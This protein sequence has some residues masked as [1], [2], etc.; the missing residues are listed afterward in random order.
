MVRLRP[1]RYAPGTAR[2]TDLFRVLSPIGKI[3]YVV[4]IPPSWGISSTFHVMD[5]TSHPAPALSSDVK[6]SPTGLFVER[7]FALKFTSLASPPGR[8]ERVE[9]I[10]REVIDFSGD[11]VS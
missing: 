3:A 7:E 2:S 1:E 6:P 11:E 9:E 4:D 8:H 5:I 10:F